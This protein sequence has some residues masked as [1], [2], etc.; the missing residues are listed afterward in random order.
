MHMLEDNKLYLFCLDEVFEYETYL[1][2]KEFFPKK[3]IMRQKNETG[4]F[5]ICEYTKA[6]TKITYSFD[7]KSDGLE[8][9][10]LEE[11]TDE[12]AYKNSHMHNLY[13]ALGT[14]TGIRLP[15]GSLTGVRPTKF[16]REMIGE[17]K[18]EEEILR[19]YEEDRFV[20]KDKAKLA[21]SIAQ[22]ETAIISDTDGFDGYSL[23][24][25]IPFCPSRCLY[26]SFLSG[27]VLK[28]QNRIEEY[29]S[30]LEKE[31][32][33][34]SGAFAGKPLNTIYIGGGTPTALSAEELKLLM[35]MIRRHTETAS[36]AEFTVEAGRPDSITKEKLTVLK[37]AGVSRISVNPQTMNDETLRL[38]GRNHTV[39]QTVDAFHMAREAGFNNINMDIIL[40]LPSEGCKEVEKTMKEL[41][42]LSPDSL[43]VHSLAIKRSAGMKDWV[44]DLKDNEEVFADDPAKMMEIAYGYVDQMGLKPYYLYRQKNIAGNLENVGFAGEGKFGIYNILMM[45]EVQTI[46]AIGAGTVS[47]RVDSPTQIGRCDTAK[48]IALYMDN[49]DDMI[50]RKQELFRF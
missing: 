5:L 38:I 13:A 34:V 1:L 19:F 39:A 15:W 28:W 17:K 22:R 7:G 32:S 23:Y 2:V 9:D 33:F 29:L 8:L 48:D 3:E 18:T 49:I 21:F 44:K 12:K 41:S 36:L 27:P 4:A 30:C 10:V 20:S 47:K 50:A 46:A 26:C 6:H 35:E 31:L 40:G 16:A 11:S 42:I 43:T 14:I 25:G 24:I 37:Q 45:E